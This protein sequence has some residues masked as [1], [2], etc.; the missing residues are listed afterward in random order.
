MAN[1]K[2]QLDDLIGGSDAAEILGIDRSTLT[3]WMQLGQIN[4]LKKVGPNYL[5]SRAAITEIAR[6]RAEAAAVAS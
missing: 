3:R 5:F 1:P 4:Y 6:Q 2:Q